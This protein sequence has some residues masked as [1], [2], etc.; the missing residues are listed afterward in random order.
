MTRSAKATQ[1]VAAK[2]NTRTAASAP[3]KPAMKFLV[4]EDNAGGYH[5]T[6][7]ADSGQT[8]VQSTSFATYEQAKQAAR[9]VHAGA[10]SASLEHLTRD[11]PPAADDTPPAELVALPS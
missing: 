8:L 1:P 6:I 10:G 5:W 7:V 11:T 2:K 9:L 4:F 3:S